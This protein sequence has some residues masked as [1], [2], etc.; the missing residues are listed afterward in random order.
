MDLLIT[1]ANGFLG[2]QVATQ[3]L[4]RDPAARVGCLVRGADE[5]AARGRLEAALRGA[6][7]DQAM[8]ADAGALLSRAD[9]VPGDMDDPA[10]IGRA[11]GWLLSLIHI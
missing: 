3:W 6:V 11:R 2:A 4:A 7:R 5:V 8:A 10:W 1:G 9:V